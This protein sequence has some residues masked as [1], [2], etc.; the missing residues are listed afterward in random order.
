MRYLTLALFALSLGFAV[1]S[2][3]TVASAEEVQP[4]VATGRS[5]IKSATAREYMAVT[6]NPSRKPRRR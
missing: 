2:T 5:E 4:E 3:E 6:A 1:V